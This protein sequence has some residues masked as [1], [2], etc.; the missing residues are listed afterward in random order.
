MNIYIICYIILSLLSIVFV[1]SGR[2]GKKLIYILGCLLVLPLIALRAPTVGADTPVYCRAFVSTTIMSWADCFKTNWE[3]GLLLLMKLIST[4]FSDDVRIYI[5]LFGLIS[6]I[7]LYIAIYRNVEYPAIG[8]IVFYTLFFRS[9]EYLNRHWIALLIVINSFPYIV[10]RK[11]VRFFIFILCAA[12]FH[13]TAIVFSLFYF[14]Y[15]IPM[16]NTTVL[17]SLPTTFLIWV[18]APF[19]QRFLNY[20]ARMELVSE[21]RGG[22]ALFVFLWICFFICYALLHNR[23]GEGRISLLLKMLLFAAVTQPLVFTFHIWAR[24]LYFI[25]SLVYLLPIALHEVLVNNIKSN[26]KIEIPVLFV[27]NGLLFVYFIK[28]GFEPFI[29]MTL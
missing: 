8:L 28:D 7:P 29:P 22:Y 4:V 14:I 27:F 9:A 1:V 20:F 19:I 15:L 2:F 11:P 25:F 5:F 26:R 23:K 21:V 16:N 17:A 13:R 3:P 10:E 12:C 18:S 6:L 24:M